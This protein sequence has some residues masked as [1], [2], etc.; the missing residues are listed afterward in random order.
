MPSHRHD[1]LKLTCDYCSHEITLT[2][3]AGTLRPRSMVNCPVCAKSLGELRE[4]APDDQQ[5]PA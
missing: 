1:T 2:F 5:Q 3:P 4:L